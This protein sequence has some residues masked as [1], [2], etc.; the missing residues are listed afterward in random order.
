M[1]F[2]SILLATLPENSELSEVAKGT[3]IYWIEPN[4]QGKVESD[5][6]QVDNIEGTSIKAELYR[7]NKLDNNGAPV[8]QRLVS[9]TFLYE[10]PS[11]LNTL[12]EIEFNS[13]NARAI[14]NENTTVMEINGELM[15]KAFENR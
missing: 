9:D 2:R 12:P 3:W 6:G 1:L 10:L 8:G 14:K 7:Y 15:N 13:S 5:K 4:N 11:D